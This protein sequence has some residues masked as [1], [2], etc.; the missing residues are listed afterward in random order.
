MA[1]GLVLEGAAIAAL[2][3]PTEG[4]ARTERGVALYREHPTPPVFWPMVL[5]FR[6]SAAA[7]VG[8]AR[9]K[10]PGGPGRGAV[11]IAIPGSWDVALAQ[12]QRGE[13]LAARGDAPGAEAALRIAI[14]VAG[15][16]GARTTQIAAA[17]RAWH[18]CRRLGAG[19][20]SRR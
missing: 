13:V 17:T 4:S 14:D 3:D 11:S 5:T 6:G 1:T 19:T 18:R 10:P 12:I 20:L 9:M 16:S 2:E 8:P 7:L 15:T